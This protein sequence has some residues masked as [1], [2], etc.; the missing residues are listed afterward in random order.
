MNDS[1]R[2]VG[3]TEAAINTTDIN[4]EH[5]PCLKFARMQFVEGGKKTDPCTVRA[6]A[7]LYFVLPAPEWRA[8]AS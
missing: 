5:D 6:H 4:L 2:S 1:F 8:G 7:C 3:M